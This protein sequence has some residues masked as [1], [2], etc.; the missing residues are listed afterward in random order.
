MRVGVDQVTVAPPGSS[1]ANRRSVG[2]EKEHK[3]TLTMFALDP[4]Q[5]RQGTGT[6]VLGKESWAL[7]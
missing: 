5:M 1:Q 3:R 2:A 4:F 6:Y 7:K